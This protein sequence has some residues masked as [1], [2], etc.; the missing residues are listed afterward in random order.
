MPQIKQFYQNI[1]WDVQTQFI[2]AIKIFDMNMSLQVEWIKANAINSHGY[3][4]TQYLN[5]AIC[6]SVLGGLDEAGT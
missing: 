1:R 2:G 3:G 5:E 4:K 6:D